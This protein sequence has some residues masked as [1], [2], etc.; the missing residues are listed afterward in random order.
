MS[1]SIDP[2]RATKLTPNT[3]IALV[4]VLALLGAA[5]TAAMFYGRQS[6]RL[7]SI[8]QEV[9]ELRT[10]VR[11]IRDLLLRSPLASGR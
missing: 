7:D 6:Q 3:P 8:E 4:L 9:R 10:E 2:E 1:T 11:Q 5:M